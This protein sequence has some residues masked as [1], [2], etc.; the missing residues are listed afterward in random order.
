MFS[1]VSFGISNHKIILLKL[2][3]N[4]FQHHSTHPTI[5]IWAIT[6]TLNFCKWRKIYT[7]TINNNHPEPFRPNIPLII[8]VLSKLS[9]PLIMAWRSSLPD[10]AR[11]L[12]PPKY[13][14]VSL[15]RSGMESQFKYNIFHTFKMSKVT[16]SKT[17]SSKIYVL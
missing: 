12:S 7:I 17:I 2:F 13:I 10:P 6:L 4:T 15:G 16:K 9:W 8:K 1:R 11:I 5:Y 14:V 3:K